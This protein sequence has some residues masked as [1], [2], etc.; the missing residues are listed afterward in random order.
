[1][2]TTTIKIG[3]MTCGGC[4]A[5]V[6]RVLNELPGVVKAEVVLEPGAA[7]V[8]FDAGKLSRAALCEAIDDAGFEAT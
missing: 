3:G 8:E 5:S 4:V 6:T 2:E 7:T 1:M